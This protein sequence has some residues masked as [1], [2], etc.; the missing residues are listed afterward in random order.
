[1]GAPYTKSTIFRRAECTN[2]KLHFLRR[3]RLNYRV[4]IASAD[5]AS[6]NFRVFC[7][8]AAHDVMFS[9][10]K[11]WGQVSLLALPAG[12]HDLF[13]RST[14]VRVLWWVS[15]YPAGLP[16]HSPWCNR[17]YCREGMGA[18]RIFFHMGE[19]GWFFTEAD[20][21]SALQRHTL[22]ICD[23][24]DVIIFK[25]QRE[26]GGWSFASFPPFA[27]YR[28]ANFGGFGIKTRCILGKCWISKRQI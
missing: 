4:Y 12:D 10:S 24:C 23:Y 15:L 2:K 26:E 1:M 6:E 20:Y 27:N 7:R 11:G 8:M 17:L 5:G 28:Y 22:N 3:S 16:S 14:T 9:N 13:S 19:R 25:M 21:F 18:R